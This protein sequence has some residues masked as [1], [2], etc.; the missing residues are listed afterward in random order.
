MDPG[1]KYTVGEIEPELITTQSGEQQLVTQPTLMSPTEPSY[2]TP[3]P[4]GAS[5]SP[6]AQ[7]DA[8]LY[9][10]YSSL[11]GTSSYTT[12]LSQSVQPTYS[13]TPYASTTGVTPLPMPINN[14][15]PM[16][17]TTN[18]P[19]TVATAAPMSDLPPGAMAPTYQGMS[20][21]PGYMFRFGEGQRALERSAAA[22]G[23][24]LSGGTARRLTRFGQEMGSQEFMNRFNRLASIAGMGQVMTQGMG[25]LGYGFGGQ[26]G[27]IMGNIG[28]GR[29]S[30]YLGQGSALGGTL[31]NLAFLRGRSQLPGGG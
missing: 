4:I 19:K 6:S 17:G 31:Q 10:P 22:R 8:G 23:G 5:M 13:T 28:A 3:G 9:D 1:G 7:L 11:Y 21:D 24:L 25:Q 16:E 2:V 20:D 26:M 29:A 30:G 15:D 18:F 27:N 14:V 12:P